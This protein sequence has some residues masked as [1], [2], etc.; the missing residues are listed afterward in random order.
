[1]GYPKTLDWF[2]T[3]GKAKMV[4]DM[5]NLIS[6]F[7]YL[8]ICKFTLFA[9]MSVEPCLKS[10]NLVT[11]WDMTKEE[12]L[13]AGERIFN[14]KRL[15]D[16]REGISRKDDTLPARLLTHHRGGGSGDNLPLLNTMLR[17]YYRLRGWYEF[18]IPPKKRLESWV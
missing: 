1:L 3:K 5:Q 2:E 8:H 6:L 13:K 12:F 14:L 9:G 11:G 18:G 16:V 15:Y 4:A 7:D 17:D 10:L